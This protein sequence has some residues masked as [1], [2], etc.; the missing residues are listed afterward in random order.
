MA[1]VCT[2]LAAPGANGTA[3][4]DSMQP[5]GQVDVLFS[6]AAFQTRVKC[7]NSSGMHRIQLSY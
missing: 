5:R 7:L 3:K 2:S 6:L 1:V 4:A